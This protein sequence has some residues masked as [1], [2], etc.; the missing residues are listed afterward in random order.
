[1]GHDIV[2]ALRPTD[3]SKK[4]RAEGN[5]RY[6]IPIVLAIF[7]I[8]VQIPTAGKLKMMMVVSAR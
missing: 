2:T 7:G 6:A 4:H 1:M 5:S 3:L 8:A